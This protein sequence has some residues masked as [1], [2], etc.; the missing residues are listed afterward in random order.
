MQH[1][2]ACLRLVLLR[3]KPNLLLEEDSS[4]AAPL[5][6]DV[7]FDLNINESILLSESHNPNLTSLPPFYSS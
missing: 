4:G 7:L 3:E 1:A 2:V 6:V 5:L